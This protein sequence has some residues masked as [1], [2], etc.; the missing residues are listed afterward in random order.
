MLA[1]RE[2]TSPIAPMRRF[3]D[4]CLHSQDPRIRTT[5]PQ[6]H[7]FI[8]PDIELRRVQKAHRG[9]RL[10]THQAARIVQDIID[11]VQDVDQDIGTLG[12]F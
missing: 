9:I 10:H 7:E 12:N 8:S 5:V 4:P 2:S 6:G 3:T 1:R 11:V